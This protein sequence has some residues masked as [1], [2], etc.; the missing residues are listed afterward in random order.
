MGYRPTQDIYG[1]LN[2]N[3]TV[4]SKD[5]YNKMRNKE[6]KEMLVLSG[7]EIMEYCHQMVD[8]LGYQP[9]ITRYTV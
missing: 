5:V 6:R 9:M 1:L 2:G 3:P 4:M 8:V 7:E